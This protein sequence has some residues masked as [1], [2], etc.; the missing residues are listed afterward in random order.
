MLQQ[1][2][3]GSGVRVALTSK[4]DNSETRQREVNKR[5]QTL[6]WFVVQDNPYFNSQFVSYYVVQFGS[7]VAVIRC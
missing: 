4:T 7:S 3:L 5:S 1:V 2:M 6:L